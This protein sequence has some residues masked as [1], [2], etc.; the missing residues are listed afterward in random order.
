MATIIIQIPGHIKSA[1]AMSVQPIQNT[2]IPVVLHNGLL[3]TYCIS[4]NI[5]DH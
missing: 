5:G 4:G 2:V 1:G 3:S